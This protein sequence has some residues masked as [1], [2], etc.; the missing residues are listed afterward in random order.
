MR[1]RA[2]AITSSF[3]THSV[4]DVSKL[5]ITCAYT[6]VYVH[7]YLYLTY[8]SIYL[9]VSRSI[10]LSIYPS[11]H[12]SSYT[13]QLAVSG[14]GGECL[15][16]KLTSPARSSKCRSASLNPFSQSGPGRKLAVKDSEPSFC[17][18]GAVGFQVGL[19]QCVF[20][21]STIRIVRVYTHICTYARMYVYTSTNHMSISIQRTAALD[22]SSNFSV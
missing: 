22:F 1:T 11:I 15:L 20:V 18:K 17:W 19:A 6:H 14:W 7:V 3:I 13:R 10:Y 9:S 2:Q 4:V 8:L 12:Q 21:D 5:R 16:P